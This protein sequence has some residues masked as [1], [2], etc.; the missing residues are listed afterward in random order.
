MRQ[1]L[2]GHRKR[3]KQVVELE[4]TAFMNLMVILVP[5]LLL[6]AVFSRLTILQ[7]DLPQA[8]AEQQEQAELPEFSLQVVVRRTS[9]SVVDGASGLLLAEYENAPARIGIGTRIE[10][11]DFT[12]LRNKLVEIKTS[13]LSGEIKDSR[14]A[15]ILYESNVNYEVIV[16]IMD[17]VRAKP[18]VRSGYAVQVELFPS[19]SV[20]DA[21]PKAD[22]R[23]GA[24]GG[25]R[26]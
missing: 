17:T 15:T 10:D 26:S 8:A 5:F 2:S 11:Y 13:M 21:P 1:R 14:S 25:Y 20:G 9:L 7:L 4:I 24:G 22:D 6:S 18:S 12:A 19:L 16:R 3:H 23:L